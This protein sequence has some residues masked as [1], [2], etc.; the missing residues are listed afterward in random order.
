[1]LLDNIH[2]DVFLLKRKEG[3]F[4]SVNDVILVM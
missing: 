4:R 1:M 2:L 3:T